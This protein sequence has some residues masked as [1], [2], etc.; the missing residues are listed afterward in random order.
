MKWCRFALG[1]RASY[2][3][4]EDDGRIVEVSGTP[5]AEHEITDGRYS[6]EQVQLLA[7]CLRRGLPIACDY[8]CDLG[9]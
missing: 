6:P 3:I 9:K 1:D 4:V 5:L 2:G 7:Q 8:A